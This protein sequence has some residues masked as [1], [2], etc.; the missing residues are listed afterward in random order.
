M[1]EERPIHPQFP[2]LQ[3]TLTLISVAGWLAALVGFLGQLWWRFEIA[4]HFRWQYAL[5]LGLWAGFL[6]LFRRWRTG[7][8]TLLIALLNLVLLVPFYSRPGEKSGEPELRILS[9][10]VNRANRQPER[11]LELV[12]RLQ[13]DI[14]AIIEATPEFMNGLEPLRVDYPYAAGEAY[15]NPA[16]SVLL[17]RRPLAA[18]DTIMFADGS[19]PT[20]VARL[21][22]ER[23]LTLIATHPPPP[24]SAGRLQTRTEEMEAIADLAADRPGPVVVVGDFNSTPWSPYFAELVQS[25]RLQ[26]ARLGFGLQTTW[27]VEQILLRIPIDHALVSEDVVVHNFRAGPDV[28]SDH[29]P[30][31]VDVSFPGEGPFANEGPFP[32]EDQD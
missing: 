3:R 22:G 10:N 8:V 32:T 19:Y 27:P 4:S 29:F 28:G 16:G 12:Q 5:A 2:I 6:A 23:P 14:V 15:L 21:D 13:P 31:I 24:R 7:A 18:A 1:S 17:S 25:T 20:I 11:L 30:I 9:A 26:D